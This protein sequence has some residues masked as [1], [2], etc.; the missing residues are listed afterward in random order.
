MAGAPDAIIMCCHVLGHCRVQQQGIRAGAARVGPARQACRPWSIVAGAPRRVAAYLLVLL[1][2]AAL[3]L[4][5]CPTNASQLRPIRDGA[6]AVGAVTA[7]RSLLAGEGASV[8][9]R[10]SC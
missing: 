8:E 7:Q 6:I 1:A 9:A 4:L 2:A 5:W 3:T 10:T